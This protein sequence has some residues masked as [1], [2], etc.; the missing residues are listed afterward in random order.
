MVKYLILIRKLYKEGV[1]MKEKKLGLISGIATCVGLVVSGSVI[2][3]LFQG[4]ALGSASFFVSL[5]LAVVLQAVI[6]ISFAELNNYMPRAKGLGEYTL[7]LIGTFPGILAI[8]GGYVMTNIFCASTEAVLFG[9]IIVEVFG[10]NISPTLLSIV[11]ILILLI[12]NLF[13][14][15]IFAKVQVTVVTL[16]LVSMFALGAVGA[17]KLGARPIVD[18]QYTFNIK[19]VFANAPMAFWLFIGLEFVL[20]LSAAMKN[21]KKNIP[22]SML[23]GL[24]IILIM[25]VI[26][27]IG[28]VSYI[29]TDTILSSAAPHI[30]YSENILG[31]LGRYWMSFLAIFAVVSTL[32]TIL[33]SVS[34]MV[35]GS[36]QIQMFPKLFAKTNK[37]GVPYAGMILIAAALIIL[38]ASGVANSGKILNLVMTGLI[39]WLVAYVICLVDVLVLRKKY[40]GSIEH[41]K[42]NLHGIPQVI[43]IGFLLY[44][45]TH[46][47]PDAESAKSIYTTSGISLALISVYAFLW[48][49]FKLKRGLFQPISMDEVQNLNYN[50]D[51]ID[52]PELNTEAV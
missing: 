7:P 18:Y 23:I 38:V 2:V 15:D 47:S 12:A 52:L 45:I 40:P 33:A 28:I 22:R 41:K 46:M 24:G 1:K 30:I 17:F 50:N 37:R 21:P 20:P 44:M 48:I 35:F 42:F 3:S 27:A 10:L 16:L 14:V 11:I 34:S 8:F 5:I 25:N 32:N 29:D 39:F 26:L 9:S 31:T 6:A 4:V 49:K 36:A 13:G 43:T 51:I 19:D